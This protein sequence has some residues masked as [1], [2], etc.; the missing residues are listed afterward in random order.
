MRQLPIE[1]EVCVLLLEQSP[2]SGIRCL[3]CQLSIQRPVVQLRR[4]TPLRSELM[5]PASAASTCWID[6]RAPTRAAA[7]AVKSRSRRRHRHLRPL[8][9]EKRLAERAASRQGL[10]DETTTANKLPQVDA[11]AE[12]LERGERSDFHTTHALRQD[13]SCADS[14]LEKPDHNSDQELGWLSS[15]RVGVSR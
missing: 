2:G 10:L 3:N 13:G 14:S 1:I 4:G 12:L 11:E 5:S 6:P 8:R 7:H 15:A 9:L